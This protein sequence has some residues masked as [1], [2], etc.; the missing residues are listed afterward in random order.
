MN[1]YALMLGGMV[2]ISSV[3]QLV[4]KI[5][6]N[7]K[8]ESR[9]GY[10]INPKVILSY[11][12]YFAVTLANSLYIY[13]GLRLSEISMLESLGYIFVPL[14]SFFVLKE[15]ITG[16]QIAGILVIIAGVLI[17]SL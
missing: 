17:F 15:K 3:S 14:L 5:S 7:E 9:I 13:K 4:L 10:F 16:R 2:F 11:A 6:A 8:H 1:K 12:V